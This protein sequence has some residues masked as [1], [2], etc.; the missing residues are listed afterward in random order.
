[1]TDS[2]LWQSEQYF[3]SITCGGENDIIGNMLMS[4]RNIILPS[5]EPIRTT[6]MPWQ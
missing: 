5:H 3:L 4:K 6:C 1:M 2:R